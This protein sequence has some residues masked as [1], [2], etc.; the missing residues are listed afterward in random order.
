MGAFTP[1]PLT[2]R[3]PRTLWVPA[4]PSFPGP[5]LL[6]AGRAPHRLQTRLGHPAPGGLPSC[7]SIRRCLCFA[8]AVTVEILLASP[9]VV[10]ELKL[11]PQIKSKYLDKKSPG[12]Q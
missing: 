5:R 3:L 4:A 12:G 8:A 2:R 10:C 6:R 9:S 7:D 11:D 1:R